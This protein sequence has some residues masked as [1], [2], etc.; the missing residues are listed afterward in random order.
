MKPPK[1]P[2]PP[3]A[4]G[5][6]QYPFIGMN[7]SFCACAMAATPSSAR[8]NRA[9]LTDFMILL[10]AKKRLRYGANE[11]AFARAVPVSMGYLIARTTKRVTVILMTFA[12]RRTIN[13]E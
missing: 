3:G 13:A 6:T 11:T 8:P 5:P 9:D 7:C 10:L 2:E 12:L 1:M 4:Y